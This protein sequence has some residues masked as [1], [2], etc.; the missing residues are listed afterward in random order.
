VPPDLKVQQRPVGIS[1]VDALAVVDVDHRYAATVGERPVQRIVVD[2]Q[3]AALIE[4]QQQM[5]TRD[6]RMR[7]AH[8]G[9][10]VASDH[11]VVACREGAFRPVVPNGQRRRGGWRHIATNCS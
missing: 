6:Q 4:T 11:Y 2:R 9:A 8:V 7:D 1:D 5:G 10:Q 3:P